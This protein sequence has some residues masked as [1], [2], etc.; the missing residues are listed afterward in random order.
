MKLELSTKKI[1]KHA[2]LFVLFLIIISGI[3][4]LIKINDPS[5]E[6]AKNYLLTN[7]EIKNKINKIKNI[8]LYKSIYTKNY[9]IY[10]YRVKGETGSLLVEI[11]SEKSS[12]GNNDIFR[13]NSIKEN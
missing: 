7:V 13:I 5:F 1:K 6:N 9:N 12:T 3:S 2:K 10:R 11:K 4:Y 8:K